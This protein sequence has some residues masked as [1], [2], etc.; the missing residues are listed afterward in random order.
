MPH[1]IEF[2]KKHILEVLCDEVEAV[3][4]ILDNVGEHHVAACEEI[5]QCQGHLVVTGVG[6]AGLIGRKLSATFASTG[7]K[8][9][10]LDATDALHGDLGAVGQTDLALILSNSG[11]TKELT[12]LVPHL[13]KLGCRVILMTSK[14]DCELGKKGMADVVIEYGAVDEASSL[15]LPPSCST[16]AML[17]L[18][19][20]VA[21]TVMEMREFSAEDFIRYHPGGALGGKAMTVREVMRTSTASV[22]ETDSAWA[23][24]QKMTYH[25]TGICVITDASRHVIG[26]ITDGDIRRAITE[27][28]S[29]QGSVKDYMTTNC[30][31]IGDYITIGEAMR[32]L[33]KARINAAPVVKSNN[34]LCGVVDVQDLL[35]L[36]LAT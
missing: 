5:L 26:V 1:Q 9:F 22:R 32:I 30:V 14:R 10:F 6:K 19:D 11:S 7:T 12:A 13:K 24:A 16:I 31:T 34:S 25:R 28:S 36:R 3:G 33:S 18:G 21:L 4:G 23:A 35:S 29:I 8:S 27:Y 15:K 20:A 17:A 2:V